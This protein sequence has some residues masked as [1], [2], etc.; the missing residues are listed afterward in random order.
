MCCVVCSETFA[1]K[2]PQAKFCSAE[3][4]EVSKRAREHDRRRRRARERSVARA[5]AG[6]LRCGQSFTPGTARKSFCSE[7]CRYAARD[8]RPEVAAGK[9]ERRRELRQAGLM[10]PLGQN[11]MRDRAAWFGVEFEEFDRT[12]IFDRDGWLCGLCSLPIDPSAEWPAPESA[13][14]DH[15]QPWARGGS[16]TRVNVQAAHLACNMAKGAGEI[17]QA[18]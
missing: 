14:V 4:R 11:S 17:G 13:S 8:A 7:R 1:P 18:A 5:Q 9:V 6:C 16:H 3:C 10:P 15:I 12:E 2:N